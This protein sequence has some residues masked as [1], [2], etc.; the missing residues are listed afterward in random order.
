M[1][2]RSAHV[3]SVVFETI[4]FSLIS[5]PA[6]RAVCPSGLAL[7]DYAPPSKCIPQATGRMVQHSTTFYMYIRLPSLRVAKW[8]HSY[9]VTL[10]GY[11]VKSL[12]IPTRSAV[13]CI[14]VLIH[15]TGRPLSPLTSMTS[16]MRQVLADIT[17]PFLN[18]L[19]INVCTCTCAYVTLFY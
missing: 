1:E 10:V 2:Y 6:M 8:D 19:Y 12:F 17:T 13:Q 4:D 5:S 14:R 7:G 15:L 3:H 9:S 11:I 16:V 18:T